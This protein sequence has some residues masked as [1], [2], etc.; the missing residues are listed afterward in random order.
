ME[1]K[2]TYGETIKGEPITDEFIEK[3]VREA[4]E[5]WDVEELIRQG[6]AV[7]IPPLKQDVAS[8]DRP[9][10]TGPAQRPPRRR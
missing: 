6:K 10:P 5:G 3:L 9:G 7:A 4:E 8:D 2:K 1:P